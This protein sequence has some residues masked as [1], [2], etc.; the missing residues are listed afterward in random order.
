VPAVLSSLDVR[1]HPDLK[2][3]RELGIEPGEP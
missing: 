2:K 3:L 1:S